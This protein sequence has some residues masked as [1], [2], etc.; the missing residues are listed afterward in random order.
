MNRTE[1]E[2]LAAL[3]AF[4]AEYEAAHGEIT[5]SE[6][7]SAAKRARVSADRQARHAAELTA[8]PQRSSADRGRR[9]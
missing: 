2:R 3:D 7:D 8:S 9:S 1:G 4:L 6:M 5:A